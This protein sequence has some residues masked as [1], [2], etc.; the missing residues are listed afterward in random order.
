MKKAVQ[1]ISVLAV[2]V[3][4]ML[5]AGCGE[6]SPSNTRRS[7][8]IA[9]EN[10]QLKEQLEQLGREIEEQKILLAKCLQEKEASE[11]QLQKSGKAQMENLLRSVTKENSKLHQTVERLKAQVEQLKEELEKL[12][13]SE[14]LK[15]WEEEIQKSIKGLTENVIRDIEE[16]AK[17]REENTKLKMKIVELEKELEMHKGPTPLPH[18]D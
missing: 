6:Q 14:I 16:I 8:L 11:E 9:Y 18:T 12:R 2:G 17:L 10:R 13:G 4:I 1:K 15:E 5:I 3:V 7:R